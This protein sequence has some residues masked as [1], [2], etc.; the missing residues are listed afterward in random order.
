MRNI[1]ITVMLLIVVA[2]LFSSI[3][4]GSDGLK[5]KIEEKG[6]IANSQIDGLG[7]GWTSSTP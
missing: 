6:G 3:V 5:A 7:S 2:L 1:L 4:A